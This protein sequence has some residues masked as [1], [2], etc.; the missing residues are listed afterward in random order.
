MTHWWWKIIASIL[1]LYGT[2]TALHTPLRPGIVHVSPDRLEP[3]E[4]TTTITT[5]NTDLLH[6]S[7]IHVHLDNDGQILLPRSVEAIGATTLQATFMIPDGL[8]NE[9]S[10]IVVQTPEDATMWLPDAFWMDRTGQGIPNADSGI[11][12]KPVR[13]GGMLFPLRSLLYETIRNL[14]FHVPMWFTMMLIMLLSVIFSIKALGS[15]D[16]MADLKAHQAVNVAL[17]FA[18]LGLITGAIW[19]RATW[20]DWWTSDAKLNGAAITTLIY[21]AYLVLR[22]SVTEERK[23]MRLAAIYNIFAFVL[24]IVFIM[25]LPRLTDSLHP[26]QGGNP[27]FD[28]YDLDNNLR[29]VFYPITLGWMLL[30]VWVFNL[31]HRLARLEYM[32]R[33]N[34]ED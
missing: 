13:K 20:G 16:L 2:F 9:L 3:G 23:R 1:L 30:G 18:S 6:A 28:A 15:N 31:K 10:D 5:Y 21:L 27:G 33:H 19:A 4:R 25:I 8:R 14:N 29:R 24:M 11:E 7:D 17:L 12:P 22:G 32:K 34:D 26:G